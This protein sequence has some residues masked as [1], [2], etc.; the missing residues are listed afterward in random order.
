MAAESVCSGKVKQKCSALA[1]KMKEKWT[2]TA[3][4]QAVITHIGIQ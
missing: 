3:G 1:Q 4:I 2:W